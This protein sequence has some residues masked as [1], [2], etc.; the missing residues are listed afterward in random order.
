MRK[1]VTDRPAESAGAASAVVALAAAIAA[2][3]ELAA[4][5]ALVG[6]VPAAVTFAVNHGGVRGLAR[7]LWRGKA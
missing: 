5:A 2:G 6:L 4:V 3:N 7:A 1:T